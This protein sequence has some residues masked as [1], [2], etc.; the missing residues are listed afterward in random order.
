[1]RILEPTAR[2]SGFVSAG[3]ETFGRFFRMTGQITALGAAA[4]IAAYLSPA[5]AQQPQIVNHG[6]VV[7]TGYSGSEAV[8]P[9]EGADP[10]DYL[11]I[12]L[13]GPSTRQGR[14]LAKRRSKAKR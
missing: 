7:V 5:E 2:P 13:D 9:P 11:R 8:A 6:Q 4:M 14:R 12:K 1:M 10:F 3:A